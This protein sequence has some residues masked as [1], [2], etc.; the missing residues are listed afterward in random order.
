M[1]WSKYKCDICEKECKGTKYRAETLDKGK[2]ILCENCYNDQKNGYSKEYKK[3]MKEFEAKKNSMNYLY[4]EFCNVNFTKDKCKS[5]EITLE[6]EIYSDKK[7]TKSEKES[8][9]NS[10]QTKLPLI[11]EY[12]LSAEKGD[13]VFKLEVSILPTIKKDH[14]YTKEE[15]YMFNQKPKKN[16]IIIIK[17]MGQSKFP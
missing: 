11:K 13:V 8:Q 2:L 7:L 17:K 10:Y 12:I 3:E 9:T 5:S 6:I 1:F 4:K 14:K 16:V 15:E